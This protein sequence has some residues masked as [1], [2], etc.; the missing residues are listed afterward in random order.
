MAS[1]H[2]TTRSMHKP[3][4]LFVTQDL[5][6]FP[7]K[8]GNDFFN[9]RYLVQTHRVAV[10]GPRHEVLPVEGISN[11]E[12]T[13]QACYF[14]PRIIEKGP[15]TT[16]PFAEQILT[17]PLRLLPRRLMQKIWREA[18]QIDKRPPDTFLLLR[19]LS[20]LAPYLMAALREQKPTTIALLQSSTEP[21]LKF[22]PGFAAKFVYF[23]D[24]RAD[25][26][27]KRQRL[28]QSRPDERLVTS[29]RLQE[30]ALLNGTD[31]AACVSERDLE[32]VERLYS[33]HTLLFLAPI[34][35]DTEY[36]S[37]PAV[38]PAKSKQQ[39]ILFTGH[40]GHPPNVD[41]ISYFL[42]QIWPL[43]LRRLPAAKFISAGCFPDAR[44]IEAMKVAPNATLH[45]D[46][47]D[48]RPFFE[49]A[50]VYVVP[51]RFGGGVRQ[52]ILEAFS[53]KRPVVATSMA[54][55]GL[56]VISGKE[57][58]LED[59]P[60]GFAERV[61]DVLAGTLDTAAMTE[62]NRRCVEE[63]YSVNVAASRFAHAVNA[64]RTRRKHQPFKVLFDLRWMRI[65][66]AG[67]I[68]QLVYEL[69]SA[70]SKLDST[71]QYRFYGPRNA[72]L[73]WHFP[74]SFQ[75]K[76]FPSDPTAE[77]I[78]DFR[79]EVMDALAEAVGAPRFM[80]REMRFLRFVNDLDFDLVHSFQ[81]FTY[82]EFNGFPTV[83][84]MPDLQHLTYPSFFPKEV[85]NT[86]E[87]L[88]RS[89]AASAN[90][91]ICISQFTF[92]EVHKHYG[93][94]R[95]KMSVVWVTPSRA[96]RIQLM[97][98][99]RH[100][101]LQA[102][103]VRP[104]FVFYPAH[105]WPHKNHERLLTA[106][107]QAST[108]LPAEMKLILT[109]GVLDGVDSGVNLSALISQLN[110]ES[111][112]HHL[113]YLTPIQLRALYASATA[114]VFP[115]L[116]EGFGMPVAEA[117]LSGCPVVC[118]GTTSLPEI[119]GNAALFFN[120]EKTEEISAALVQICADEDLRN[121]MKRKALI[122]RS[123]FSSWLP[124]IQT[125]SIY[126]KVVEERFS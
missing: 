74:G 91:I 48:I 107:H 104:P 67:G 15:V 71:N 28:Q 65:G 119:A 95:E 61:M 68:E 32:I 25:F 24:V 70:I 10:V 78:R 57:L 80:N 18:V 120:P 96:C 44:V 59:T 29:F 34:P 40:L 55:E 122:R 87:K 92:D 105:N 117:I 82:P 58:W 9:L 72:L 46:V 73:D 111:R 19:V 63:Q 86:R 5:P 84:T 115:S 116:F 98:E 56:S 6:Y 12:R 52:K 23:H 90:H 126:R 62:Q 113:G 93:V 53:M 124:A 79:F 50:S 110:L 45:A 125:M 66:R 3:S 8:N 121:E 43:I 103:G 2:E 20:N 27:E 16:E 69:A 1:E 60:E 41:A 42:K 36:F 21:W 54:V 75:R 81:G 31:G 13:A 7:G 102:L 94:P 37:L 106:F 11:L 17:L 14:W 109:G 123:V 38:L 39:T 47:P 108:L 64:T 112:V 99:E 89:S 100:R 4:T 88:F 77:R 22:L 49:Q 83:L 101:I 33:P 51:M 76:L 114:L 97:T 118:S 85:Y 26:E 35:I 30:Q